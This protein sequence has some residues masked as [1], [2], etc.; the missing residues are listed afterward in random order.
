[1]GGDRCRHGSSSAAFT[2]I[3]SRC[4][5]LVVTFVSNGEKSEILYV[6]EGTAEHE[7]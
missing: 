6:R 5:I 4:N 1:M 7:K 2:S 3:T